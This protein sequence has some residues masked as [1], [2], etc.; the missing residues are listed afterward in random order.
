MG[1]RRPLVPFLAS[2]A[3]WLF[4]AGANGKDDWDVLV[5]AQQWPQSF[6]YGFNLGNLHLEPD[7]C[8][9]PTNVTTWTIHGLWPSLSGTEGPNFCDDS[10]PFDESQIAAIEDRMRA[11]WPSLEGPSIEFWKH[12]WT[13]HG[14][15]AILGD[16]SLFPSQYGYFLRGLGMNVEMGLEKKLASGGVIPSDTDCYSL[17]QITSALTAAFNETAL[18]SCIN[19][20][21]SSTQYL[22]Q[23]ELCY[24]RDLELD[25]E[26]AAMINRVLYEATP[27]TEACTDSSPICYPLIKHS[28]GRS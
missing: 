19:D 7:A 1:T 28:G 14:T 10:I 12:E 25:C 24:S 6:C 2:L 9:L 20:K 17:S 23:V 15:C 22:A 11:Q 5:F 8:T 18:V 16:P 21:S 26:P 3:C 27:S 13:K 4:V